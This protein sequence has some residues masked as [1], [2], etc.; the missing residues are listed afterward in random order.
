MVTLNKNT[1]RAKRWING[2]FM[3]RYFSIN[4]F[5]KNPSYAKERAEKDCINR[6]IELNGHGFKVLGGNSSFFTCGYTDETE[7]T[8]FIETA[9]NTYKIFLGD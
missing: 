2:Y 4:Q 3:S 9:C 5:Y 7:N 6:M 1:E 8:L